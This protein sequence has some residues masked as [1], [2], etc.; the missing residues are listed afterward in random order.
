MGLNNVNNTRRSFGYL[1]NGM[2]GATLYRSSDV[3]PSSILEI[4]LRVDGGGNIQTN[5]CG[6]CLYSLQFRKMY[7][8]EI[9]EII[10]K[11]LQFKRVDLLAEIINFERKSITNAILKLIYNTPFCNLITVGDIVVEE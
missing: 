7:A 4:K 2:A 8:Q 10:Y 9:G 1:L 3:K 5:L 11:K 6:K